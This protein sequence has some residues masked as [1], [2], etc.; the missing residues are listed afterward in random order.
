MDTF[1]VSGGHPLRGHI[2][3][4]GAKNVAL[5][6]IVA[7]LLTDE[8]LVLTNVPDISDVHA[9]LELLATLGVESNW[10]EEHTLTLHHIHKGKTCVP[11]EIGARIRVSSLVIGPLLARSGTAMIPNPGGCRLGAR[12]IDRHIDAL[13]LLGADVSY[14]SED[15][16]FHASCDQLVGATVE[17]A[18]NTHTGTEALLLASV[19]AQGTT[20][21]K[22]AAEEIEIDGLIYCLNAMGANITRSANR[23]I[24]IEGVQTLHGATV[25]IMPDRNEE[26]TFAIAAAL[27]DGEIF[28]HASQREHLAQFLTPFEA[29]G[30][31]WE[32][33]DE[34]TTRYFRNSPLVAT[35]VTTGIHPGFMTDW[36]APWAVLMTAA[37]GTS[38]LHET[39]FESRFSY[40]SQLHK[41]G[42]NISFYHPQVSDPIQFYNFNWEDRIDGAYQGIII[43]GPTPLHNAVLEMS[44]LR[45]GATLVLA[46]LAASGESYIHNIGQIDRGYEHIEDRLC[47]LGAHIKRVRKDVV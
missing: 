9:L 42:A 30:G 44:D 40:V 25:T 14:H 45:A 5:K 36:Q 20:V 11:L 26:V 15:G 35:D 7:S 18:K 1:V 31:G 47:A 34:S 22:N 6:L 43:E 38:T 29:A 10:T 28:V 23:E 12:P 2:T 46:A 3:L 24:A 16:Y 4:G 21:L 41:M 19:L 37:T 17:F 8:P 39:V 27:T 13:K 33:V 32:A